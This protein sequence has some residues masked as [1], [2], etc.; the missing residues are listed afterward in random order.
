MKS[1]FCKGKCEGK[2]TKKRKEKKLLLRRRG[3][4]G[5]AHN[6]GH[7]HVCL[8]A[9]C[10]PLG[11]RI[12]PLLLPQLFGA[13][14]RGTRL[15]FVLLPL[16]FGTRLRG[17]RLKAVF[18]AGF[19]V[20][21]ACLAVGSLATIGRLTCKR[22]LVRALALALFERVS[23]ANKRRAMPDLRN[24]ASCPSAA[25][26]SPSCPAAPFHAGPPARRGASAARMGA[27]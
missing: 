25:A 26:L 15:G 10:L 3:A 20:V 27:V 13:R 1:L 8:R 11:T 17:A 7:H 4:P 22:P 5:H 6:H 14:L 18:F 21:K 9:G 12:G 16:L 23:V 2:N 19:L 24:S